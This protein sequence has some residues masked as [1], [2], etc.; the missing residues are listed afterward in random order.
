MVNI[1]VA[2]PPSLLETGGEP[3]V[4]EMLRPEE[5]NY[6]WE[7]L[8]I[9]PLAWLSAKL[10]IIGSDRVKRYFGKSPNGE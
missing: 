4:Q 8:L 5:W 3:P 7:V 9:L 6:V 10:L 2:I 1:F